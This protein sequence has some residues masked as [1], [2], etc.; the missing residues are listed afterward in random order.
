MAHAE[1]SS[2]S[3]PESIPKIS[4]TVKCLYDCCP[5]ESW[6]RSLQDSQSS[7]KPIDSLSKAIDQ[8]S[9]DVNWLPQ[10][11]E[12]SKSVERGRL[13]S[14]QN[15]LDSLNKA[16]E[17]LSEQ[18]DLLTRC[19]VQQDSKSAEQMDRKSGKKLTT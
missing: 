13:E 5:N 18:V 15:P 19:F 17:E 12:D 3:S 9:K 2:K 4:L 14:E 16:M 7:E 11:Q 8:L 10:R 1:S 6:L